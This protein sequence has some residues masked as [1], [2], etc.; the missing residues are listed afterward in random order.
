MSGWQGSHVCFGWV[1]PV[2]VTCLE[3]AMLVLVPV[4]TIEGAWVCSTGGSHLVFSHVLEVSVI[5]TVMVAELT[6]DHGLC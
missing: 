5:G 2:M 3:A 4:K 6:F 1:W